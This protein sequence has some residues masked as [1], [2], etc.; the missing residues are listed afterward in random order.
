MRVWATLLSSMLWLFGCSIVPQPPARDAGAGSVHADSGKP[1]ATD[2][3]HDGVCDDTER[4][5]GSNLDDPD[6][7][8]DGFP[9]F[10]EAVNGFSLTDPQ[11]PAL[12]QVAY[13]PAMQGA[14][15]DFDLR[16]TVDGAGD[17]A[18]GDFA[19]YTTVDS[20]KRT[21]SDFFT[22]DSA[23]AAE[24]PDN[25]RGIETTSARFDSVLGHTRLSF[26]LRFEYK[27]DATYKC[28]QGYGFAYAVKTD[29]G[30]Q[31]GSR[32]YMLVVTKADSAALD[33]ASYCLP[34]GCI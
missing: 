2:R 9:D 10:V 16:A 17:G 13:L 8:H 21:A 26:R 18:T 20:H 11:S 1:S 23:V 29:T 22:T 32:D 6:S 30:K 12:D 5:L 24:P 33:I 19:A 4:T 15:T 31:T 27:L 7:D 34:A 14:S 28:A 3:D 25:V